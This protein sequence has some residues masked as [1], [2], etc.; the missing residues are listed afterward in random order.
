MKAYS[1][2]RFS[3]IEQGK[4]DSLRRQMQQTREYCLRN[5]LQLDENLTMK[6]LG[7]SAYHGIHKSKG[8]LSA[9]LKMVEERKIDKGS[10][11]IVESLDR[12]SREEISEA[13]TQFM[14]ILNAGIKIVTLIDQQEFTNESINK[15][16]F[17]LMLSIA[18]MQ[19]ANSESEIKSHR[20]KASWEN[21]RKQAAEAKQPMTKIAPSWLE[22]NNENKFVLNKEACKAIEL[23]FQKRL[24]GKGAER[25]AKELNQLPDIWKPKSC[26]WRKSYVTKIIENRAVIGELA[27]YKKQAG[28]RIPTGEVV[29]NYY[30]AA[31]D[32][33]LFN[34]VQNVNQNN[35]KVNG[36]NLGGKIGANRNLFTH[37]VKC[38][39]CG[40]PMQFVDKG[41]G[42]K[43]GQYL[44]CD[45]SRRA[46]KDVCQARPVRYAEV[47]ELIFDDLQNIDFSDLL[48][49]ESETKEQ[50]KALDIS[51]ASKE[52]QLRQ[53]A[54]EQA[55][56]RQIIKRTSDIELQLEY[57]ADLKD[58]KAEYKQLE[59]ELNVALLHRKELTLSETQLNK[60]NNEAAEVFKRLQSETDEE[61]AIKFRQQ[62]KTALRKYI[63]KIEIEP[64]D[65]V[66]KRVEPTEDPN[67]FLF[68]SS[69]HLKRIRITF[70]GGKKVKRVILAQSYGERKKGM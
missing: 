3:S 26:A 7:L 53:N 35:R 63:E 45:N 58:S 59:Q 48:S 39:L 4:G 9:F 70:K 38:S 13:L 65:R 31:V 2:I 32:V 1:Y 50:I 54:A 60:F 30:P 37:L 15:N 42:P 27:L 64:L 18:E 6:D 5:N 44:H 21:K 11:L 14:N 56:L 52:E 24:A 47:V 25:I 66:Y 20:L 41:K 51:I 49:G 10:V 55:N 16:P 28:K 36:G 22:L 40:S 67:V 23:I 34:A 62:I 29:K 68:S 12:L 57:E 33:D 46:R 43:G 17:Q 61:K 69:K 19:R 8:A